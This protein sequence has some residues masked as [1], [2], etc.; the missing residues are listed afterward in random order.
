MGGSLRIYDLTS[1]GSLWMRQ[2][3]RRFYGERGVLA[4]VY[5]LGGGVTFAGIIQI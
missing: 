2:G 3:R 5:V 4:R 1:C